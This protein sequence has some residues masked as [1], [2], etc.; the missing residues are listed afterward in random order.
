MSVFLLSIDLLESL[1]LRLLLAGVWLEY[2]DLLSHL[3]LD[4]QVV[5]HATLKHFGGCA[6][7]IA[8]PSCIALF[9]KVSVGHLLDVHQNVISRLVWVVDDT[10]LFVEVQTAD[11]APIDALFFIELK[12][13]I[14]VTKD[15]V[16][17]VD[18]LDLTFF[19][20][21]FLLNVRHF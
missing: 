19:K 17:L 13:E 15:V 21:F 18:H 4:K 10:C 9:I 3:L 11:R 12:V 5:L 6:T 8:N 2:C 20:V 16:F 1:H 14:A 7:V